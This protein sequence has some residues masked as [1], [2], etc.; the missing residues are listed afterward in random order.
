[1][2]GKH[3][4]QKQ[5]FNYI[6]IESLVPKLHLLWRIHEAVDLKFVRELTKE[7]YCVHSDRLSVDPEVHLRMQIIGYL[8][9]IDSD[10]QLCEEI[11]VNLAYL[12][13]LG[14]SL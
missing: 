5:L 3:E 2:Q 8:Y 14:F 11:Q 7:L 13:F 6:D 12:C 1:M 4:W 10:P 9:G